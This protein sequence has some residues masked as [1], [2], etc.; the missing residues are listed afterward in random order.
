MTKIG[1]EKKVQMGPGVEHRFEV[2]EELPW[3]ETPRLLKSRK[4]RLKPSEA[5]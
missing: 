5:I 2:S 1:K 3:A 4:L